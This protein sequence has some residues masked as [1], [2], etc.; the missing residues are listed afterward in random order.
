MRTRNRTV[1]WKPSSLL[2]VGARWVTRRDDSQASTWPSW[3][4]ALHRLMRDELT[5]LCGMCPG[6]DNSSV[7]LRDLAYFIVGATTQEPLMEEVGP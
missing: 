3:I 2:G 5:D 1:V 6:K 4:E 7:D